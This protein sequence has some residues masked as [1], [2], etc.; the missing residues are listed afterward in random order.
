MLV[1]LLLTLLI[2]FLSLTFSKSLMVIVGNV[3]IV[4]RFVKLLMAAFRESNP[5]VS[6]FHPQLCSIQMTEKSNP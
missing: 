1:M 6:T 3:S 4:K 2:Q 5:F